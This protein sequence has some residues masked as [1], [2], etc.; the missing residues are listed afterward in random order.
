MGFS[1][2]AWRRASSSDAAEEALE[3]ADVAALEALD[4]T[5]ELRAELSISSSS[6][7]SSSSSSS[8]SSSD[9]SG[10]ATGTRL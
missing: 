4:G 8:S 2:A 10:S 3:N 9:D 5:P 1:R 6:S 7:Y